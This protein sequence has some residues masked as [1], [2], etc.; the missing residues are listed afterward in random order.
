MDLDKVPRELTV[1]AGKDVD[2]EIPYTGMYITGNCGP[3]GQGFQGGQ[4][5]CH[6][7]IWFSKP[8]PVY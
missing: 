6:K 5:Y 8:R 7:Y 2:I 3:Y 1:K 4:F